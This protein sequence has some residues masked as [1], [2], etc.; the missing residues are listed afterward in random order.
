MRATYSYIGPSR[1]SGANQPAPASNLAS[2]PSRAS[3]RAAEPDAAPK[4]AKRHASNS[5]MQNTMA[6]CEALATLS[7]QSRASE[8]SYH[9]STHQNS[10]ES[11][12][13]RTE[14]VHEPS[15][16]SEPSLMHRPARGSED[17]FNDDGAEEE[18]MNQLIALYT[19][20]NQSQAQDSLMN[21]TKLIEYM[22]D[23][24]NAYPPL[25]KP[26][27]SGK[28]T[29]LYQSIGHYLKEAAAHSHISPDTEFELLDK[30]MRAAHARAT[31]LKTEQSSPQAHPGPLH[32]H[33][34]QRNPQ[35]PGGIR[36]VAM[37]ASTALSPHSGDTEVRGY[38]VD[39]STWHP[40]TQ[41]AHHA[42]KSSDMQQYNEHMFSQV[43]GRERLPPVQSLLQ[44]A[45][46]SPALH[47][48]PSSSVYRSP[49][50]TASLAN[51]GFAPW[52]GNQHAESHMRVE[53]RSETMP[54]SRS[55]PSVPGHQ[56][57]RRT[58]SDGSGVMPS[59]SRYP[60]APG[61]SW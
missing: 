18:L 57:H 9:P 61:G 50:S 48:S 38:S 28:I 13:V 32:G 21:L 51:P 26:V 30:L 43:Y 42:R 19:S 59:S 54:P 60:S 56:H 58:I 46:G 52:N 15:T 41:Q 24:Q 27:S 5:E 29:S 53:G 3:K 2:S 22:S 6:A 33:S 25:L 17:L 12:R 14:S 11:D 16:P 39:P 45:S 1:V 35:S 40:T 7:H 37:G 31:D 10:D 49:I 4:M 8:S 20:P 44:Y 36:Y 34:Y 47:R 23:A 55:L